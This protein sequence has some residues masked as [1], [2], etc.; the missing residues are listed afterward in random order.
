MHVDL[1]WYQW[2]HIITIYIHTYDSSVVEHFIL[3]TFTEF[4]KWFTTKA[5]KPTESQL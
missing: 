4:A 3:G 2:K 5:P 1:P